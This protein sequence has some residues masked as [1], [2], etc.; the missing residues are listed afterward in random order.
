MLP[1]TRAC[2]QASTPALSETLGRD[3]CLGQSCDIPIESVWQKRCMKQY[4]FS[5]FGS[6]LRR[7][8]PR[9]MNNSGPP[10]FSEYSTHRVSE[11]HRNT[12]SMNNS[13]SRLSSGAGSLGSGL[14]DHLVTQPLEGRPPFLYL[15]I[16]NRNANWTCA[17]PYKHLHVSIYMYPCAYLANPSTALHR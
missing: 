17:Y 9:S 10:G 1:P 12:G 15:W 5:C 16:L 4:C 8:V 3:R 14:S 6:T 2:P 7:Y 11:S 13:G